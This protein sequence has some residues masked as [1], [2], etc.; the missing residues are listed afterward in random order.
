LPGSH[1]IAS[2]SSF[3][4]KTMGGELEAVAIDKAR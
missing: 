3:E 2:L 1:T 4:P